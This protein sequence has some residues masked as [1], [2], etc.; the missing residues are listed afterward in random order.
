MLMLNLTSAV[1]RLDFPFSECVTA[2]LQKKS[3]LNIKNK[4]NWQADE[5]KNLSFCIPTLSGK[6]NKYL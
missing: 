4:Y 3:G 1:M 6:K 5:L 2:H